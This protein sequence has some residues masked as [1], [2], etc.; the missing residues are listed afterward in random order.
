VGQRST[1]QPAT[2]I[3]RLSISVFA[4]PL[5][6][7]ALLGRGTILWALTLGHNNGADARAAF[8]SPY[9]GHEIDAIATDWH[10]ILRQRLEQYSAGKPVTFEDID[11]H[12]PRMT[13]FRHDVIQCTR[14]LPYGARL[15]YG[16]L[17]EKAGHPKAAR[18]VGT[19]MSTNRFPIIIPCHRVVG[20]GG[21]LGGYSAPQGLNLKQRLLQM[22]AGD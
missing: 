21:C 6:Q 18:A 1:S 13:S 8:A 5:G 12:L 9:D 3:A 19:A 2:N 20:A 4:T 16:E 17:A 10:A 14:K 15:T 7:W 11:L 22:E